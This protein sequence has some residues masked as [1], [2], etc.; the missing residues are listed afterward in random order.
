M[1]PE[2][3]IRALNK[4]RIGGGGYND[5]RLPTLEEAMSLMEPEKKNSDFVSR[6]D[7]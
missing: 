4:Q 1:M 7:V 6:S 5:W 2:Q 3:Y